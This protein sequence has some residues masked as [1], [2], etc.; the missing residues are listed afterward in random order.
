M[1]AEVSFSLK[2]ELFNPETVGRLAGWLHDAWQQLDVAAFERDVLAE[3]P[4]L[5]LKARIAH[6][7][8]VM[9]IHLRA[10]YEQALDI[11]TAALPELLDPTRTDDD[12]GD[13][14][15]APL[16]HFVAQHGA[17][18]EHLD[19][20]LTALREI[21]KRF[22]AEDAIR[23]FINAFPE[24]TLDF[25]HDC[26]ADDNYH[27]RR[28]A[29]EG[30]RPK[31]PWSGRV[32]IDHTQPLPILDALHSDP[33]RFVTRSVANHLNDIAKI[34][35]DLVVDTLAKW[36]KAG[37]QDP[38]EM[39]FIIEHATRTLVKQGSEDAL[40]LMG[41]G[42]KPAIAITDLQ[43]S[44][45]TVK[46]GTA[47]E[48]GFSL[49]AKKAQKLMVDYV[50]DF[51]GD[52]GKP[53]GRKVFKLKRLDVEP[54]DTVNVKKR[55]PM[56]LMTTRRLYEGTHTITLQVNGKAFDSLSFELREK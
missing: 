56:K 12:F 10:D 26:A 21:T 13:F 48:F 54:G 7:A 22:S 35:P 11:I 16:S 40:K 38:K 45:P 24:P 23:T 34:D 18:D 44:T 46:V 9:A 5:E 1:K 2:D 55:H 6:I 33:T 30:T 17:T 29:S 42:E 50:M 39:A 32:N 27:V 53:G 43:T 3:F 49:T 52:D 15:I 28:W 14:I 47:F 51:A 31:L 36:K 37:A 41:Y 20:S 8:D 25:L 4:E 19:R